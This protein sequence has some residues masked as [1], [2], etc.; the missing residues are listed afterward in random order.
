[1]IKTVDLTL[2]I[3]TGHWRYPNIIRSFK[4]ID[5]GDASNIT[6]YELRSHWFTHIDFPK[7]M[8]AEG[9]LSY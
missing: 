2:P 3:V 7:H 1:M 5:N 4:S 9:R 6:Y 8:L